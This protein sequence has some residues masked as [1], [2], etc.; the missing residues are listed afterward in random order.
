MNTPNVPR[1]DLLQEFGLYLVEKKNNQSRWVP[2]IDIVDAII[3]LLN[4]R[5]KAAHAGDF[6]RNGVRLLTPLE[7]AKL[8]RVSTGRLLGL[9]NHDR[10]PAVYLPDNEIRFVEAELLK[11]VE[12]YN[13][14]KRYWEAKIVP[15]LRKVKDA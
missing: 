2:M 9:A 15:D 1:T 10:V 7:A 12:S 8:L 11:W 5:E 14:S 3:L 6:E 4:K 13:L